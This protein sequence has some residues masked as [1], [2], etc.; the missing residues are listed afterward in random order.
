M[1]AH[2]QCDRLSVLS[3][4]WLL[5]LFE[6]DDGSATSVSQ[7]LVIISLSSLYICVVTYFLSFQDW[8]GYLYCWIMYTGLTG[9]RWLGKCFHLLMLLLV[10]TTHHFS[11]WIYHFQNYCT[12]LINTFSCVYCQITFFR[13]ILLSRLLIFQFVCIF[14][15]RKCI[16]NWIWYTK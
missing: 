1:H 15:W 3:V 16:R 8:F 13:R 9:T 6:K 10:F 11:L 7:L 14:V 4:L 12:F 2:C 5:S